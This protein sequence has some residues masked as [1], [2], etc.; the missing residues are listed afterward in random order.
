MMT[1]LTCLI[2][3]KEKIEIFCILIIKAVS[4]FSL[5][6]SNNPFEVRL[7]AA[8]VSEDIGGLMKV[9]RVLFLEIVNK[10]SI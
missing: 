4:Q 3:D 7:E 1:D 6:K 10:F 9:L 2:P 8:K 5:P